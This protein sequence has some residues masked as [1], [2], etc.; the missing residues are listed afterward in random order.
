MFPP[1][2]AARTSPTRTTRESERSRSVAAGCK[3]RGVQ[4][5]PLSPSSL[6]PPLS[7]SSSS[8]FGLIQIAR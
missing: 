4:I 3:I 1:D 8:S 2:R 6:L 7:S 5:R